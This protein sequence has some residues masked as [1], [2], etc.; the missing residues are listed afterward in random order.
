MAKYLSF[1]KKQNSVFY[2]EIW[3]YLISLLLIITE[4]SKKTNRRKELNLND[5]L[6]STFSVPNSKNYKLHF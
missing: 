4:T 2:L 1:I 6:M 5:I 3:V